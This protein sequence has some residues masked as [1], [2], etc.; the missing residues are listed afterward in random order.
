MRAKQLKGIEEKRSRKE[1]LTETEERTWLM[2]ANKYGQQG[3]CEA[4]AMS[5]LRA[6][7]WKQFHAQ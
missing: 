3:T 4:Q 5:K 6:D 1:K 7:A 2:L